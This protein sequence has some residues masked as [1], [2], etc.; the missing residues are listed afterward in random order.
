M[1]DSKNPLVYLIVAGITSVVGI[2]SLIWGAKERHDANK[3]RKEAQD[4]KKELQD[5][6]A[7]HQ[8][9]VADLLKKLDDES[10]RIDVFLNELEKDRKD[11]KDILTDLF[12]DVQLKNRYI[13]EKILD[14]L[15]NVSRKD[16]QQFR[17]SLFNVGNT[18]KGY[19]IISFCLSNWNI[20]NEDD[21]FTN[22]SKD[23]A[24]FLV[25]LINEVIT[26]EF[27]SSSQYRLRAVRDKICN[28]K[29]LN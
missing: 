12:S 22:L 2:A 9:E 26:N 21:F 11:I 15:H 19:C 18:K 25:S 7:K 28:L 13:I 29:Y 23:D 3:A 5:T 16:L 1:S 4:T 14:V 10:F 17:E 24:E 27:N 6:K 20:E 8:K